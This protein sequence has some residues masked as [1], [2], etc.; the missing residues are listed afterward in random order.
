MYSSIFHPFSVH[1][2]PIPL[3]HNPS[4]RPGTRTQPLQITT[5]REILLTQID[6]EPDPNPQQEIKEY[7]ISPTRSL[8]SSPLTLDEAIPNQIHGPI[9]T[10]TPDM[11]QA[12]FGI[13]WKEP[14]NRNK[15]HRHQSKCQEVFQGKWI[16]MNRIKWFLKKVSALRTHN[17]SSCWWN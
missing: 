12:S 5:S 16:V 4:P 1:T 13:D 9:K 14:Y 15:P 7:H 8:V 10:T 2:I 17:A 3:K 11:C 6:Q